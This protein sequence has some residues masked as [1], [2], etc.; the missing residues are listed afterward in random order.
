MDRL[1]DQLTDYAMGLSY[2]DLPGDVLTRA[3]KLTLDSIGCSFGAYDSPPAEIARRICSSVSCP[4]PAMVLGGGQ[5]TTPDLAAFANGI[6]IRYLDYSDVYWSTGVCHPS[7]MLGPVLAVADSLRVDGKSTIL[8]TVLGYEILCC[9]VDSEAVRDR[10]GWDQAVYGGIAAAVVASK[11]LQLSA[12]QM[13]HAVS[14]AASSHLTVGQVR[15]G[16]ISHWKGCS[17]ANASRNAVFSA[18]LAA[19]GMTGPDQVFEGRTGVFNATGGRFELLPLGGEQN[20]YRMMSVRV[21]PYPS[22]YPSHTAI[23]AAL[24]VRTQIPEI[25]QIEKINIRAAKGGMGYASDASR[26]SPE[27][28]ESADHSLPFTVA[29]ALLEGSVEIRHF[30][31]E[32]FKLPIVRKLMG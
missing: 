3:K 27:T 11:L 8:G 24:K 23:E 20:L 7:D 26:W 14:L 16:E 6:M 12:I 5:E 1:V 28:R 32:Y 15:S 13:K 30:K 9:L 10:R 21:K 4:K 2:E 17:V 18:L 19:E 31:D 25:D 29:L 22:G